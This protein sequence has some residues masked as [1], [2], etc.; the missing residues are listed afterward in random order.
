MV[1]SLRF[2]LLRQAMVIAELSSRILGYQGRAFIAV[3]VPGFTGPAIIEAAKSAIEPRR[4]SIEPYPVAAPVNP[5]TK[6]QSE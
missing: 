3:A 5:G 2:A 4:A 6:R 1:F